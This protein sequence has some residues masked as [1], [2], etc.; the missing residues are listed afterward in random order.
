MTSLIPKKY[1]DEEISSAGGSLEK[2]AEKSQ[3]LLIEAS[4]LSDSRKELRSWIRN[5][6]KRE[7]LSRKPY[8]QTTLEYYWIF[9]TNYFWLLI[10]FL[11]AEVF[12]RRWNLLFR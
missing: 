2:F 8:F 12:L 4:D 6:T 1:S 11:P 3:A 7:G 10:I 9:L 5:V